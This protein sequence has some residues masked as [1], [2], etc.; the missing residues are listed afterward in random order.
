M[1]V[2]LMFLKLNKRLIYRKT[3]NVDIATY[4]EHRVLGKALLKSNEL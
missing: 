4:S 3:W 1:S 2:V